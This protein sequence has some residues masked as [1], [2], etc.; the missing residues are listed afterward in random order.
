MSRLPASS[1]TLVARAG[2]AFGPVDVWV[3]TD[4]YVHRMRVVT[5]AGSGGQKAR[6]VVTMTLSNYG[7]AVHA[8]VPPAAA[9]VDAST[10]TI[11]GLGG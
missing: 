3:G 9:T 2:A 7:E 1:K 6:T 4:G 11:P 10:V 8:P 5:T